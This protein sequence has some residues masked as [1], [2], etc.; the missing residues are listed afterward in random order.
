MYDFRQIRKAGIAFNIP[1]NSSLTET[2]IAHELLIRNALT[3][4][5]F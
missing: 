5:F 3:P 1:V 2:G 4:L